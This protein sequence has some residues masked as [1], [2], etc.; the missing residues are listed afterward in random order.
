MS[1]DFGLNCAPLMSGATTSLQRNVLTVNFICIKLFACSPS[2]CSAEFG[3]SYLDKTM[4]AFMYSYKQHSK[5]RHR[6]VTQSIRSDK[7]Q[8]H[9]SYNKIANERFLKVFRKKFSDCEIKFHFQISAL[10]MSKC[11]I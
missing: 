9:Q 11:S 7:P 10:D 5:Q 8:H 6:F 4:G 1:F 2:S 3:S